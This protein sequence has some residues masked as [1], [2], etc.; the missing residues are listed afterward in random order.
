M[1]V[2]VACCGNEVAERADDETRA[3]QRRG[4]EQTSD[5]VMLSREKD[6]DP[7]SA[8]KRNFQAAATL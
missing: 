6:D 1:G 5:R 2:D 4:D 8:F 7:K 3:G